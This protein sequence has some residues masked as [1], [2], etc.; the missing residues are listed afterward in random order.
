MSDEIQKVYYSVSEAAEDV[1]VLTSAIRFWDDEYDVIKKRTKTNARQI[2]VNELMLF[3]KIKTLAKFM[4]KYGVQAVL[5][6]DI[7]IKVNP[8]IL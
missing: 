2:T 7:Q 4:N 1:G 5:D 6:G 3:H 8:D